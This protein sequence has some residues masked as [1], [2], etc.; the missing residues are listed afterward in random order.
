MRTGL[1]S[2]RQLD[3]LERAERAVRGLE[4]RMAAR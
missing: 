3:G 1:A 2:V 4:D